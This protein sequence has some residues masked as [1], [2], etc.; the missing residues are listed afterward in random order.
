MHDMPTYIFITK[1]NFGV[2]DSLA[3]IVLSERCIK[4]VSQRLEM[5]EVNFEKYIVGITTDGDE[6]SWATLCWCI[7]HMEFTWQSHTFE[8]KFVKD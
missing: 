3:S 1:M 7:L 6:K 4:L 2:L 8:Q 5:F